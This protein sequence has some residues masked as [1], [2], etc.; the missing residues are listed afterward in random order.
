MNY[1]AHYVWNHRIRDLAP[2]PAFVLGAALPDLWLRYSRRRRLRWRVIEAAR[3]ADPQESR[4]RAG[5]LSHMHADR[6]FHALPV[7]AAWQ[8]DVRNRV[9]PL[10]AEP[11]G[12]IHPILIDFLIHAAL[13]LALD[14]HLLRAEPGLVGE[15][16]GH[17]GRCDAR[18]A[19]A[20]VGR[21]AAVETT[22]LDDVIT[23]FVRRRFLSRYDTPAGLVEV[24]RIIL[25]LA[26]A[27]PVPE[28]L[29]TAIA[30][31]ACATADP[32]V[33]WSDLRAAAPR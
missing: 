27:P 15:F 17:V 8:R 7:F 3:P 20:A 30:D 6:D 23:A 29:L 18:W 33:V 16:Y 11:P 14:H 1:L 25:S 24:L 21:L 10:P 4:L 13:E 9:A 32:R 19:A 2:D 28:P 12:G 22:G 5:L 26:D 31:L